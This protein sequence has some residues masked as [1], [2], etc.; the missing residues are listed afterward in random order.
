MRTGQSFYQE[1]GSFAPSWSFIGASQII[2][3]IFAFPA[4]DPGLLV[5]LE[6]ILC[7]TCHIR[8]GICDLD[9]REPAHRLGESHEGLISDG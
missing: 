2:G 1:P 5:G 3:A 9:L 6:G 7:P 8:G 4:K